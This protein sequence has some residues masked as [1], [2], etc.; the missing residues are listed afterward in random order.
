[1]HRQNSLS[2][3][4]LLALKSLLSSIIKIT[5]YKTHLPHLLHFLIILSNHSQNLNS[6]NY[7]QSLS[8]STKI[9]PLK[10][11]FYLNNSLLSFHPILFLILQKYCSAAFLVVSIKYYFSLGFFTHFF[12]RIL[13]LEH[14]HMVI[15]SFCPLIL[16]YNFE[17]M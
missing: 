6:M 8:K 11:Q 15:E 13:F 12:P 4:T 1:M 10:V 5:L 16:V 3:I 2:M 7:S 14:S 17:E 9:A